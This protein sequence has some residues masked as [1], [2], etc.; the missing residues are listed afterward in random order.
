MSLARHCLTAISVLIGCC[1]VGLAQAEEQAPS[2]ASPIVEFGSP[3]KPVSFGSVTV[4]HVADK[5]FGMAF[6]RLLKHP[7]KAVLEKA[8]AMLAEFHRKE[9]D[10]YRSCA[11]GDLGQKQ[12][13][14]DAVAEYY[15]DVE[16]ASPQLLSI[17]QHGTNHCGGAHYNQFVN[18]WSF[19]LRSMTMMGDEDIAALSKGLG[20]IFKLDSKDERIAFEKLWVDAWTKT[21]NKLGEN[22]SDC[23]APD[24]ITGDE[25]A[26]FYFTRKGLAVLVNDGGY[27]DSAGC[28]GAGSTPAVVPWAKLKPFLKKGQT[29]LNAEIK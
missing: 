10:E 3:H 17:A 16:Y 2:I 6:P 12:S 24:E 14:P 22:P 1:D 26:N 8:N 23:G 4:A 7:D 18:A 27:F 11:D 21:V 13:G 9:L 28:W 29:L 20:Q 25:T 5:N 19:D 15:F